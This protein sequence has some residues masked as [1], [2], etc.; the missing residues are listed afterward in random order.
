MRVLLGIIGTFVC[1]F[2]GFIL[3]HGDPRLLIVPTEYLI[4]IGMLIGSVVASN[5]GFVLKEIALSTKSLFTAGVPDRAQYRDTFCVLYRFLLLVRRDGLLML[6]DQ[7]TTPEKSEL[8]CK[9]P[10]VLRDRRSVRVMCSALGMLVDNVG[11]AELV[12]ELI[13][14]DLEAVYDQEMSASRALQRSADALPAIGIV[15]AVL[16]IILTMQSIDAG[17]DTVGKNVAG[18]LVGT[19]AGV[20]LAYGVVGPLANALK[21]KADAVR[22]LRHCIRRVVVGDLN[23]ISP[24][25]SVDLARLGVLPDQRPTLDDVKE[26]LGESA[27]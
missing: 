25:R 5:P 2:V 16:G 11:N 3:H 21:A 19:F 20:F 8:F 13:Q 9:H 15:A 6:E 12:N 10:A 27:Q 24:M 26:A 4:I 22:R 1:V 23:G 18:A 14:R 17:A 7:L